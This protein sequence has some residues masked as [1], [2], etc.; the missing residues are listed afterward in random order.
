MRLS[1]ALL[2]AAGPG[3][4]SLQEE[5]QARCRLLMLPV[6]TTG[7]MAWSPSISPTSFHWSQPNHT[8]RRA[9]LAVNG[10][11]QPDIAREIPVISLAS[12]RVVD[13]KARLDDYVKK[14]QLLL[15]DSEPRQ[16]RGIR[17]LSE[18]RE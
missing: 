4:R 16:H 7:D 9:T 3:I 14:G 1:L 13:I 12:G 2:M 5:M 6:A 15:E 11:V 10:T 8:T 18:G 17:H